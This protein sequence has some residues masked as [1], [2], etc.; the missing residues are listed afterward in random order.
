MRL[1]F[2]L[3]LLSFASSALL[4]AILVTVTLVNTNNSSRETMMNTELN[5]LNGKKELIRELA[6][7]AKQVA[8][9]APSEEEAIKYL[10]SERYEGGSG[11]LFAFAKVDGNY[12]FAFHGT[13]PELNKK[14]ADITQPDVKGFTYRKALIEA[15]EQNAEGGYVEYY[16]QNPKSKE[17]SKKIAFAL[18]VPKYNWYLTTGVYMDDIGRE[19]DKMSAAHST[20]IEKLVFNIVV[21]SIVVLVFVVLLMVI[22]VRKVSAKLL[23]LAQEVH[24]LAQDTQEVSQKISDASL[25]F[26]SSTQEQSSSLEESS[27]SLEELDKMIQENMQSSN[28]TSSSVDD[29]RRITEE[30]NVA[31]HDSIEAIKEIMEANKEIQELAQVI[32]AIG[33]KTSIIDDIVFQT[34][35][36][37]FNA[38]VEAERAGEHGRGFAVVAQEVGS[39]AEVS[40]K[41]A[42]EI[43]G[44]VKNS[45]LKSEAIVKS[46]LSK[47][48]RGNDL[49][50]ETAKKLKLIEEK[51]HTVAEQMTNIVSASKEQSLGISQINEA[52]SHIDAAV[53]E[54]AGNAEEMARV[55]ESLVN[56]AAQLADISTELRQAISGK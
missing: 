21:T 37:S 12:I 31:M 7:T 35:L 20:N 41:A 3:S 17:I 34:K 22:V 46:N 38:S 50:T 43:S 28:N 53:Q 11:Y 8:E 45:V 52:V 15:A 4:V 39:L 6:Q 13:K 49:I 23:R 25:G 27:A 55:G 9:T 16:Y 54:N 33:E 48:Q 2:K 10:S 42:Q 29:V 56:Y 1:D 24:T 40:G 18:R 14:D 47:V 19:L 5:L 30:G 44:I 36:L 32:Q 26:S 51:T